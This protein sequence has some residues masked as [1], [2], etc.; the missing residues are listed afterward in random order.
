M[1]RDVWALFTGF[2]Y[3][4]GARCL[5]TRFSTRADEVERVATG[6]I[7]R[8]ARQPRGPVA[9][10]PCAAANDTDYTNGTDYTQG[11]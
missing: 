11:A 3:A 10:P 6:F 2:I 7:L 4:P 8:G 9:W 5:D 1:E